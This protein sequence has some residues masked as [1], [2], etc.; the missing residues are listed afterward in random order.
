MCCNTGMPCRRYR[1]WH[2][3]LSMDTETGLTC[4]FDIH[5][6]GKLH[7]KLQLPVLMSW[8]WHKKYFPTFSHT[9]PTL[10]YMMLSWWQSVR[11]LLGSVP[12]PPPPSR[13]SGHVLCESIMLF[14][15]PQLLLFFIFVQNK[16]CLPL[17]SI[18]ESSTG[19]NWWISSLHS[20]TWYIHRVYSK[21]RSRRKWPPITDI[22]PTVLACVHLHIF[23]LSVNLT[24]CFTEFFAFCKCWI[25]SCIYTLLELIYRV[26]PKVLCLQYINT[27]EQHYKCNLNKY[28]KRAM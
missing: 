8:V 17:T 28:Y 11:S 18:S 15:R 21:A 7:W 3:T 5:W 27:G 4:R 16:I 25:N 9:K 1:T 2:P 6:H 19:Y 24:G 20:Y 14:T 26:E 12:Y 23:C 10:N 22:L 13:K